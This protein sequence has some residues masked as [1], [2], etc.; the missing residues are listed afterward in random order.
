MT[1]G[2]FPN[3][4]KPIRIG[5]LNLD[6]RLFVAPIVHNL[7]TESGAVTERLIDAYRKK[8]AGGWGLVM[9]EA[10]RVSPDYSQFN[11]MIGVHDERLIG[12]LAELAEAVRD[13]GARAGIQ[14]MHPGGLA[15]IRWNDRQPVS[16]SGGKM[17]GVETREL[18][19]SEIEKILDDFTAA[20][21]RA[22][23]AGF[24]L[25]QLH[26]AHGFLIHQFMSPLWN[27]RDDE[28]G[29]PAAFAT[30][31][32]RRVRDAVGPRYSVG[33][34]ISGHEFM[35]DGCADLDHMKKLAPL[36]VEAGI[37][38]LDVSAGSTAGS[39][40]WIGQPIYYGH[41]CIVELAEAIKQVVDLPVVTA[42]RINNPGLAEKILAR[43]RADIIAIGRGALADPDFANK[44]LAGRDDDIRQCTACYIGCAR[45]DSKG[46]MCSVNYEFGRPPS[47]YEI[48][49]A[50]K[51]RKVM[52]IG[53]GVAGMEAARVAALRGHQVR[54]YEKGERLGGRVTSMAGAIPHV[55]T[56][57]I[58][59]AVKWLR[60]QIEELGVP[61]SLG[62]EVTPE[63]VEKEA[64]DVVVIATG[65]ME[66]PP[67]VPGMDKTLVLTL[68]DYLVRKKETGAKVAVI[69]GQHG[70]EAALSLARAGKAVTVIEEK[71]AIALAP[72]L[73]TRRMVL[74]GDMNE[75]GVEVL[76][77][78]S[79]KEIN[80]G[81]VK[82]AL[83]GGEEKTVEADTVLFAKGRAPD[84]GLMEK[85]VAMVPEIHKAGDCDRPLHTF[86]AFHS[87]N[88]IARR[89]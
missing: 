8:G 16:P 39:G 87:A 69:G 82:V 37:D 10:S 12:G 79:L 76:A 27:R 56:Q 73:L 49:P 6:N 47:E 1:P 51:P 20:A 14:I 22:K 13:G 24:D 84:H 78:A 55:N 77:G 29:E 40:D 80:K 7:A 46:S 17:A 48:R 31:V 50:R 75:A 61:V 65:A 86:H 28:W 88:R 68:E 42:G 72:Y 81:S 18:D 3:L 52:V 44:A 83:T 62:T 30:E 43:E 41:G 58:M 34:R 54:L 25:V 57:D 89:I 71:R 85:L 60:K 23:R 33:M 74:I 63:L 67:E 19:P 4:A 21:L 59:L 5:E 26:G 15:P 32:I 64:P 36:L 53:G 35:G 11:R 2:K 38:C 9:V 66:R 70:A 45:V